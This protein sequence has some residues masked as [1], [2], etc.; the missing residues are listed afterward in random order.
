MN[1]NLIQVLSDEKV[2]PIIRESNPEKA[3]QIAEA[4]I[5]GGIKIL[6]INVEN[7]QIYDVISDVSKK[8][9]FVR[10]A[11]SPL[12]RLMQLLKRVRRCF[13]HLYSSLIW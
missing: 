9:L 5:A 11:L 2:Y 4:L 7:S 12:G 1:K 8:R 10:A 6:E 3:K 13:L